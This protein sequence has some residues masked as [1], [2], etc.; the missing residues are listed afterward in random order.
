VTTKAVN[1]RNKYITKSNK[2]KRTNRY[3]DT[4]PAWRLGDLTKE[5]WHEG[6]SSLGIETRR[7]VRGKFFERTK[8]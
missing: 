2:K 1:I 6:M 4:D 3:N 7:N 5:Q 8:H